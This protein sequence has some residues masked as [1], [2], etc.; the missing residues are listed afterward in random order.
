[1]KITKN[2]K[3]IDA[4]EFTSL[5]K[6]VYDAWCT[7]I[8]YVM[9]EEN[10]YDDVTKINA[11]LTCGH[12][13]YT[14]TVLSPE[15]SISTKVN[16]IGIYVKQGYSLIWTKDKYDKKIICNEERYSYEYFKKLL[17][18]SAIRV[19]VEFIQMED[20]AHHDERGA[21]TQAIN[22]VIDK[23]RQKIIKSRL[24]LSMNVVSRAICYMTGG[25]YYKPMNIATSDI[26]QFTYEQGLVKNLVL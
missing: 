3:S 25:H 5:G 26:S 10:I 12:D 7:D 15:Y 1:M 6:N 8:A 22:T 23:V 24:I 14:R 11:T 18:S 13:I 16:N 21:H 4:W 19:I 17:S 20:M 2:E 9:M